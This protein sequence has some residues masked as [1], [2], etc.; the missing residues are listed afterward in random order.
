MWERSGFLTGVASGLG[1]LA[2]AA[3]FGLKDES[4]WS[5]ILVLAGGGLAMA[6]IAHAILRATSQARLDY[7][8]T[9]R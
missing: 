7:R 3:Y 6:A 9:G 1:A 5:A 4:I 2:G 8:R